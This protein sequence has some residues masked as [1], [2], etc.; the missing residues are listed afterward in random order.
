MEKLPD[1]L[2]T[3]AFEAVVSTSPDTRVGFGETSAVTAKE[4]MVN[5]NFPRFLRSGDS[6]TFAPVVFNR[7]SGVLEFDVSVASD[8]LE[9]PLAKRRVAVRPGESKTVEFAAKVKPLASPS[10]EFGYAKVSVDAVAGELSDGIE[11]TLPVI[12]GDSVE[13]VATIGS[14][15]DASFDERL[16]LKGVD[17]DRSVLTLRYAGSLFASATDALQNLLR[18]PYGCVEQRTSAVIP[19]VLVKKLH[20][21]LG[22]PYDLNAVTVDYYAGTRDGVIKKTVREALSDYASLVNSYRHSDGGLA[23]WPGSSYADFRMTSYVLP[24]LADVRSLGIAVE[25]SV[26]SAASSYLK[27]EFYANRRPYCYGAQP[28]DCRYSESER[29]SAVAAVLAAKPDDYEAYKMYKL[30]DASR[31]GSAEKVSELSAIAGLLK[32]PTLADVE[33]TALRTRAK[34]FVETLLKSSLAYESRGAYLDA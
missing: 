2:T 19:H 33:K 27:R 11:K 30:V 29:L 23:Y 32:I 24:V 21:A 10:T 5:D 8:S 22:L 25:P 17:R 31:F 34:E 14:T 12:R 9:I 3:W 20:D 13:S 1:N 4:V 28:A 15:E 6:V 18:Y 16:N 7:T 26:F